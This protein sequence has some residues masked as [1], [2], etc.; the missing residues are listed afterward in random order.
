MNDTLRDVSRWVDRGDRV[1]IATAVGAARSATRPLGTKMAINDHGEISGNVSGGCVEAAVVEIAERV[2]N[3][4]RPELEHFGIADA[5]ER[6]AQVTLLA[7]PQAGAKL[8][9]T[10]D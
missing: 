1:A 10:P 6:A 4:G 9:V 2:I 8:V 5:D 7:G 3:T